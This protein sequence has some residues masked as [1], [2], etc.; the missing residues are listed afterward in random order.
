M[1]AN[2]IVSR[3]QKVY[4]CCFLKFGV[5]MRLCKNLL[6]SFA[7]LAFATPALGGWNSS[8]GEDFNNHHNPWF[9]RNTP[10]VH[11]CLE[12]DESSFSASKKTI[13][14]LLTKAFSYWNDQFQKGGSDKVRQ[15]LGT[16][17]YI[18]N[19][20]CDGSEE[21]K[22]QFGHGTLS[23]QQL[24]YFGESNRYIGIAVRTEYDVISLRGKG[25]VFFAS[26]LG[27]HKIRTDGLV[28]KPWSYDGLLYRSILHE[29]GHV[30]GLP[31][32]ADGLMS[33]TYLERILNKLTYKLY[34]RVDDLVDFFNTPLES[35]SCRLSEEAATFFGVASGLDCLHLKYNSGP[36]SSYFEAYASSGEKGARMLIGKIEPVDQCIPP[37]GTIPDINVKMS[38]S[39][40]FDEKQ[41]VYSKDEIGIFKTF[42]LGPAF[43]EL[44]CN[45]RFLAENKDAKPVY[46]RVGPG[47]HQLLGYMNGEIQTIYNAKINF[48]FGN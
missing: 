39:V 8:G 16:H 23:S 3:S 45:A 22:F 12:L 2:L 41:K 25:F 24:E 40:R 1:R 38:M 11:Y 28:E 18:R 20:R 43:V 10:V 9:V 47:F 30:L 7:F 4:E 36:T 27:P 32:V 31:H 19:S 44:G 33:E 17:K 15:L 46:F 21:I 26:D 48:M 37:K 42:V 34:A 14:L 6:F 13:E 29:I 5:P 35:S